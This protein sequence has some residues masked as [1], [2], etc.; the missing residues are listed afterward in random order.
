[1]WSFWENVANDTL[2]V[3]ALGLVAGAQTL[4]L[5]L[6]FHIY[7]YHKEVDMYHSLDESSRIAIG[8]WT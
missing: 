1:V 4:R 8:G 5:A 2:I 7:F 6:C 3:Q